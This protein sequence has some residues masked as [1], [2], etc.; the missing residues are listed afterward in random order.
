[1]KK[2]LA[3]RSRLLSAFLLV[4]I[5]VLGQEN[6]SVRG[7]IVNGQGEPVE[8]VHVGIPKLQMG[9][10]STVDGRFEITA[11]RD[12]LEFIHVSYQTGRY[13]V[14]GPADDVLIVLQDNE[15]PPA[16]F[17]GGDTK[18]KY[19]LRPGT[20][21]F[22]NGGV[23]VFEPKTGSTKGVEIGSVARTNKPFLVQDIRFGIWQNSIPDCVVS[24]NIY[25][26]EDKDEDFVNVLQKPMYVKVPESEKP[27]EFHIR[28]EETILLEPGRYYISFQ[29]VDCDEKALEEYLQV[30]ESERDW[31]QMRLSTILYFKSSYTRKAALGKM[32]HCPVNIG[33]SVKGLEYQ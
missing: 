9:T 7:R 11:P 4:P 28:P 15:L 12:T 2:G 29:I 10:I 18:E 3:I 20:K 17:I 6:V 32:E 24:V 19:L 25:R 16:V 26:I 22:G 13:A 31:S 21:I 23:L 1:M 5:S 27:Q 30:P 33:I 14:T 8:Y